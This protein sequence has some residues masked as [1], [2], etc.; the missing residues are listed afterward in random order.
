[1]KMTAAESLDY[2]V[3]KGDVE[4]CA[5]CGHN[6]TGIIFNTFMKPPASTDGTTWIWWGTCPDTGDPILMTFKEVADA[7]PKKD[8][9]E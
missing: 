7:P 1:M 9:S 6:H 5:R 3:V 4:D 2:E 8:S